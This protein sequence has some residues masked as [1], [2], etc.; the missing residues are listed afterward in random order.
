MKRRSRKTASTNIPASRWLGYSAASAATILTGAVSADAEIHYSG[1]VDVAFGGEE[2][3]DVAFPLDQPGDSII[4]FHSYFNN[5]IAGQA[6]FQVNG[7]RSA[8]F[9]GYVSSFVELPNV[10]QLTGRGRYIS[11]GHFLKYYNFGTMA[12]VINHIVHGDWVDGGL[13]FVGFRFD[14]GAGKQYGWARVRMRDVNENF[15]FKVLDYAYADPGESIK[16]GQKSSSAPD[17]PDQGS[18]GILALGAAGVAVWRRR[19]KEIAA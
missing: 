7:L 13:G 6:F 14:N 18:L 5:I 19:R 11:Q 12:A 2:T 1:R 4:F 8:G 10:S 3:K 16:A 9:I 17:A 15:A